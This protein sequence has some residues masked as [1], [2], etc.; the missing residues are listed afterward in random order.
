MSKLVS[1]HGDLTQSLVSQ[2]EGDE[3]VHYRH[4][5]QDMTPVI[6]H[7]RHISQKVNTAPKAGNKNDWRYIGAIP[8]SILMDWL[9][10]NKV[11]IDQFARNDDGVKDRFKNWFLTSRD[12]TKFHARSY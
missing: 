1:N 8:M 11:S 3:M 6:E 4:I 12:M 10:T 2:R 7:V 9:Q 5:E